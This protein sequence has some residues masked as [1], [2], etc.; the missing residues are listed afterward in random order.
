M[1]ENGGNELFL[2]TLMDET[3]VGVI[4]QDT[5]A[6]I[7]VAHL[8]RI[9]DPF[10]TTKNTP[11]AGQHKGTGLGLAVSYGIVQEH[12]GRIQVQSTL[13]EG[14]TFRLLF[15]ALPGSV[16]LGNQPSMDTPQTADLRTVN[17]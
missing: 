9:Y 8:N 16:D 17:A 5:G 10:F 14:A 2:S 3:D 15:P 1:L 12:G 6:G 4:F 11:K 7:D 13:G